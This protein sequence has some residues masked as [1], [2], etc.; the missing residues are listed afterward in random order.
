ML[1]KHKWFLIQ[2]KWSSFS[3]L[4]SILLK[5]RVWQ[6]FLTRKQCC[7]LVKDNKRVKRVKRIERVLCWIVSRKGIEF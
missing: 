4:T 6:F 2:T 3:Y 1:I 7:L 5:L